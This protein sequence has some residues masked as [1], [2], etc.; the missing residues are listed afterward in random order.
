MLEWFAQELSSLQLGH[1]RRK[2][3]AIAM[4]SAMADRPSGSIPETFVTAAETKAAYRALGAETFSA[5]ALVQALQQACIERIQGQGLVLAIQDTTHLRFPASPALSESADGLWSHTTLAVS[6]EGV[7]L[8][9]LGQQQ[10]VRPAEGPRTRGQR[11][12]RP[13]AD[14]ESYRWLQSLQRVHALIPPE[15][16]VITLA[17]READIF[18][19][20]AAERPDHSELLIRAAHN[21]RVTQETRYLWD[22]VKAAPQAGQMRVMLRRH[23]NRPARLAHLQVRFA[24]VTLQPPRNGVHDPALVPVTV[25]AILVQETEAPAGKS[26]VCWL[27]LTTLAV[28]DFAAACECI[29]YYTLRWLIERFHY[30]LKS[31]CRVQQSQLRNLEALKRL[32]VLYSIVAWRLLWMTYEARRDS[33]QPCTVAFSALEWQTLWALGH[34][35]QHPV[36]AQPPPLGD[37]IRWVARLGGFLYRRTDGPPGVKVLWRGLMRLQNIVIGTQLT[38]P[39]VLGN[40]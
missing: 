13:I 31:G 25:T 9:L 24:A 40:A 21:R 17:D 35:Q 14:K 6:D 22:T 37:V 16:T 32:V 34:G 1:K 4:L 3:R 12:E 20:L 27:L 38:L 11:R 33:T 15:T 18:E 30:T 23:P 29:R 26:P 28:P 5:D 7:P 36:P 2:D 10:W 8:G 19:L 39:G